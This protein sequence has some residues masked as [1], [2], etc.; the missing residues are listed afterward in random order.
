LTAY[1]RVNVGDEQKGGIIILETGSNGLLI[2]MDFLERF[3]KSLIVTPG[4]SVTLVDLALPPTPANGEEK[5][6]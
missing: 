4:Q 3:Q 5:K 2:G 1:G 6:V